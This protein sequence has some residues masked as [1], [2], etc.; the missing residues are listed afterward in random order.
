MN[1][2]ALFKLVRDKLEFVG[3]FDDQEGI[4]AYLLEIKSYIDE[5]HQHQLAGEYLA[6]P[7]IY[8]NLKRAI[9]NTNQ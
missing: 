9:T 4:N 8:Y 3:Y 5:R 1:K 7:T 6:V 2:I